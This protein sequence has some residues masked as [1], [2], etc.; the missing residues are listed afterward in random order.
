MQQ[1][2]IWGRGLTV[3][4]EQRV[5]FAVKANGEGSAFLFFGVHGFFYL[6]NVLLLFLFPCPLLYALQMVFYGD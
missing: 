1:R 2:G 6:Q 5:F 3:L 4:G